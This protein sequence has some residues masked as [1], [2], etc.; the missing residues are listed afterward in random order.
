LWDAYCL[1][2]RTAGNAFTLA[3]NIEERDAARALIPP[4]YEP[5]C[6]QCFEGLTLPNWT[7]PCCCYQKRRK[8]SGCENVPERS[9]PHVCVIETAVEA[10]FELA[11]A[12]TDTTGRTSDT[13]AER[14]K[15]DALGIHAEGNGPRA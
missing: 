12:F 7:P 10:D 9:L 11:V 8:C 2:R 4:D 14:R 13:L 15:Q 1:A 3:K 6:E 5:G